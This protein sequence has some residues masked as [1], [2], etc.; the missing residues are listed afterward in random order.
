[1]QVQAGVA[2]PQQNGRL[3]VEQL[4][5]ADAEV[6][7][8]AGPHFCGAGAAKHAANQSAAFLS[9]M[10]ESRPRLFGKRFHLPG[11]LLRGVAPH[12][13]LA[14]EVPASAPHARL[15][16]KLAALFVCRVLLGCEVS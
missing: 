16:V 8:N 5:R 4:G 15:P 7:V 6:G 9:A 13:K 12:G 2:M 10:F 14:D 1:M 3:G 11:D